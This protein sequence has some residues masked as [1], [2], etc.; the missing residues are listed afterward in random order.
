M[1]KRGLA[2]ELAAAQVTDPAA[3]VFA[4]EMRV[5]LIGQLRRRWV[6]RGFKLEQA[7]EYQYEWAYLNLA[8]NGITGRLLWDWT[9][10]M[11][12]ASLAPVIS[13]WQAAGIEAVVWDRAPGH[14]GAAYQAVSMLRI[15][16]PPYSP[17]LNPA[18][19]IFEYLRDQI[20]G[21][22][23]GSIEAKQA[24]VEAELKQLAQDPERVKSLTG[25]DWIRYSFDT[26]PNS[27][28]ALR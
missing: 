26:L 25:W 6:P 7:V 16:Q 14:R 23:Y 18:E 1:E 22:V 12:G 8:V 4:D 24:A 11:K 9:A 5:G 20:E 15:E 27:S 13:Q 3:V 28:V 2:A 10:N 21:H 17:Q 19:R